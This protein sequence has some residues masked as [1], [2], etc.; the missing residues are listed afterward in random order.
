MRR[1]L[2]LMLLPLLPV[3]AAVPAAAQAPVA[4]QPG[5]KDAALLQFL[6]A[7]FSATLS[8]IHI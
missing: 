2:A 7:A 6:D 5:A 4:A 3:V 8:L 1:T